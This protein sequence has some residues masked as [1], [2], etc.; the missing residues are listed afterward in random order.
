MQDRRLSCDDHC[1]RRRRGG[2][3]HLQQRTPHRRSPRQHPGRHG[4][5]R[6][7]GR[8]RRQRLVGSDA[9][10]AG[11]PLRLRPGALRERRLRRRDEPRRRRVPRRRGDPD[12]QPGRH[13]STRTRFRGCSPCCA[14]PGIGIVAPRVREADGSLSPDAAA[15]TDDG[16]GGRPEFHR[17]GPRSPSASR[18]PAST[19]PSTRSNGRSAPSCWSIAGATTR[20]EGWTSPTSSTPRRR[21]SACGRR[22]PAGRRSTRRPRARC[23]SAAARGRARPRTP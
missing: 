1:A 9:R 22:T 17:S 21:T 12:P 7:L 15:R 20:S 11:R 2:R 19:R 16:A 10:G 14:S 8:R 23:T 4:G 5:P 6:L 18:T 3:R 13:R